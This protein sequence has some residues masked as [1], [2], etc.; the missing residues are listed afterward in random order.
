MQFQ[1]HAL[2]QDRRAQRARLQRKA[3]ES[4]DI[5]AMTVLLCLPKL[6]GLVRN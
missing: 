1:P 4:G 6:H 5:E 3:N 2:A